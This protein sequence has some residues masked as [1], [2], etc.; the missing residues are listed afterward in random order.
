MTRQFPHPLDRIEIGTLRRK[1][2]ELNRSAMLMKPRP[3]PGR[4]MMTGVVDDQNHFSLRTG[5]PKDDPVP[6]FARDF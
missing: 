2:I 6:F 4:M 5:M 3:N 1:K